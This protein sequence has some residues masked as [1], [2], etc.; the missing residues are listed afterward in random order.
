A[1]AN[2]SGTGYRLLGARAAATLVE[3]LQRSPAPPGRMPARLTSGAPAI[4]YKTGTSYGFRDAWAAGV[5]GNYAV[6]VWVG[7]ADGAPRP[8]E[9]GR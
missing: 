1:A 7:R 8:G 9:T 6:V 5:S 2:R 3:V 4:A